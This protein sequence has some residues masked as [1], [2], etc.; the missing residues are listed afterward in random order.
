MDPMKFQELVD[1]DLVCEGM[2]LEAAEDGWYLTK[3]KRYDVCRGEEQLMVANDELM[4]GC[5]DTLTRFILA[6][7][8]SNEPETTT[9]NDCDLVKNPAHY[10]RFEIQ[11]L[12][13][14][15][16][17]RLEGHVW[18]IVKYTCRAGHKLYEGMSVEESEVKDLEKTIDIAQKRIRLIKG[19]PL[20]DAA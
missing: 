4:G 11:P 2:T 3:G 20:F 17:N 10:A 19:E 18:N 1:A 9:E 6:N 8:D 16:R 7:D 14:C 13:F 5:H 12:E 15:M